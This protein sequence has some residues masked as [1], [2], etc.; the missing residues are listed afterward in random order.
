M[1]VL[2]KYSQCI[3]SELVGDLQVSRLA[4]E[5]LSF[6]PLPKTHTMQNQM[7]AEFILIH[8]RGQM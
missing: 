2:L 7:T 4:Q 3:L 8:I 1:K 6:Q 5:V